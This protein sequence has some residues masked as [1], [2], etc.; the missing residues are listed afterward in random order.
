VLPLE[1][2]LSVEAAVSAQWAEQARAQLADVVAAWPGPGPAPDCSVAA[3]SGWAGALAA[4]DWLPGD[5]LVV[6]SLPA[7]AAAR[8]FL[9]STVTEIV[10]ASPVPAV[11]VPR[12][13]GRSDDTPGRG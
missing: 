3:G 9:G 8:V 4:G 2:R 10:R 13:S 11:V 7:R 1:T 6:G 12:G 5:V